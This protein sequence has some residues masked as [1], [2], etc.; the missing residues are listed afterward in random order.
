[1]NVL[2]N[3]TDEQWAPIEALANREGVSPIDIL[4][5]CL[6]QGLPIVQR[7]VPA[8]ELRARRLKRAQEIATAMKNGEKAPMLGNIYDNMWRSKPL[9]KKDEEA[10]KALFGDEP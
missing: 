2:L 4:R 10:L 3:L 6:E 7:G 9:V 1:M 8:D 5:R